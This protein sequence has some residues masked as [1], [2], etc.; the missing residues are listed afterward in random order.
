M[1]KTRG[2]SVRRLHP[3]KKCGKRIHLETFSDGKRHFVDDTGKRHQCKNPEVKHYN[4]EE[5]RKFAK[6]RG[7]DVSG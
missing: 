2:Y 7:F 4:D 1:A 3:C 6:D 5:L